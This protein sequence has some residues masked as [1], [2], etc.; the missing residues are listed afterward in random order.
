MTRDPKTDAQVSDPYA[1]DVEG[2]RRRSMAVFLACEEGPAKDISG[3]LR[4]AADEIERLSRCDAVTREVLIHTICPHIKQW[5]DA[6]DVPDKTCQRCPA[7]V[8]TSQGAGVQMCRL[9]AEAAADA[10]LALATPETPSHD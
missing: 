8:Q 6:E 4:W 7:T 10:V 9:N 3:A 5:C 2:L 1:L